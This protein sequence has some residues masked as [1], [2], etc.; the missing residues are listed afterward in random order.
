MTLPTKLTL[1]RVVLTFV[2]IAL[3]CM[4]GVIAK[5]AALIGF[6]LASFTD[7]LDG[8]LARRWDQKS[9]LGALLD[10][11]A[12]KVLI[13]GMFLSF[14]VLK[15]VPAWMVGV[16]AFREVVITAVRLLAARRQVVLAAERAG[17]QKMVSQVVTILVILIS[18]IIEEGF[19]DRLPQRLFGFLFWSIQGCLWVTM[20]LTVLSGVTFFW[21][22][23]RILLE[24]VTR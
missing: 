7:W 1:L 20:A 24:V 8:Y 6:L 21:R 11:V 18:I 14:V 3:L 4:S 13:L 19:G 9:S 22:H 15:R 5:I 17:K 16:I 12:D 10:P 2:I 23:R